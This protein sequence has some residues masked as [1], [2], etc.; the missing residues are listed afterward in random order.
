VQLVSDCCPEQGIE[1]KRLPPEPAPPRSIV[2]LRQG[3]PHFA[4]PAAGTE[5]AQHRQ[6]SMATKM[7]IYF[8]DPHSPWQR[9]SNENGLLRQYF[10]T[11]RC[12]AKPTRTG[13]PPSSTTDPEND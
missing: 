12:T 6:I 2:T 4:E 9:G 3:D 11:C 8:C 5:L 13:S 1:I 10:P 7:D